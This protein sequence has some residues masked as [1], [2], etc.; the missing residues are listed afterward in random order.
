MRPLQMSRE[1]H[2]GSFAEVAIKRCELSQELLQTKGFACLWRAG[3]KLRLATWGF[4]RAQTWQT[5]FLPQPLGR[6]GVYVIYACSMWH[7]P[8][9]WYDD[10]THWCPEISLSMSMPTGEGFYFL[11]CLWLKIDWIELWWLW[12]IARYDFHGNIKDN[13]VSVKNDFFIR[14]LRRQSNHGS[15]PR[16][17][18]KK[19]AK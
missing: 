3:H 4:S 5:A 7:E 14:C 19:A 10:N 6:R 15:D 9:Y 18:Q 8:G 13:I 11:T 16:Y 12:T 1:L 17:P 2:S